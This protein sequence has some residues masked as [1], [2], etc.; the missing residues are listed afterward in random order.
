ME[1]CIVRAKYDFPKEADTDLSLKVGDIVRIIK[2]VNDEWCV[3]IQNK[4]QGQFPIAF[5]DVLLEN[6]AKEVFLAVADFSGQEDGDIS[7]KKDEIIS[8]K[9]NVDE[10]WFIG[11]SKNSCGLCPRSFVKELDFNLND[12]EH[13]GGKDDEKKSEEISEVKGNAD[14]V[15][16][17]PYGESVDAFSAQGSDELTFPK[18]VKIQ[19]VKEIDSFWTEGI[20]NGKQGKFP[21]LFIKVIEPLPEELQHKEAD[22]N[23]SDSLTPE[24]EPSAKALFMYIGASSDELSFDKGDIIT[25]KERVNNEW[26]RGQIGKTEGLFPAN[27][28]EIIVDL[29]FE[30]IQEPRKL[31]KVAQCTGKNLELSL[32]TN[33]EE[34]S[35]KPS[36]KQKP[37]LLKPKPAVKQKPTQQKPV[38]MNQNSQSKPLLLTSLKQ[39]QK[40]VSPSNTTSSKGAIVDKNETAQPLPKSAKEEPLPKQVDGLT[41]IKSSKNKPQKPP[42][43]PPVKQIPNGKIKQGNNT[44][45]GGPVEAKVKPNIERPPRPSKM[46]ADI[47][48]NVLVSDMPLLVS[49]TDKKSHRTDMKKPPISPKKPVSLNTKLLEKEL[50]SL[51]VEEPAT[52]KGISNS[53]FYLEP[54]PGEQ[55]TSHVPAENNCTQEQS[56]PYKRPAPKRP[57]RNPSKSATMKPGRSP[58]SKSPS[59]SPQD[60]SPTLSPVLS[61]SKE[62]PTLNGMQTSKSKTLPPKLPKPLA[63]LPPQNPPVAPKISRSSTMGVKGNGP[64]FQAY[65]SLQDETDGINDVFDKDEVIANFRQFY[66]CVQT[67]CSS[68]L[69][70]ILKVAT[71]IPCDF[72][73]FD[74]H[75]Q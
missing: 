54:D 70:L 23:E 13:V 36:L 72:I 26:Y 1:G 64:S 48:K 41:I 17:S 65:R 12:E 75:V 15:K 14:E 30:K 38:N 66:L 42:T 32:Q 55:N 57:D 49:N 62:R 24:T 39:Q 50:N 21:S 2:N 35:N 3:G 67:K 40:P 8:L 74:S 59:R 44:D 73:I 60:R 33:K 18:G 16:V 25:L 46:K 68:C 9:E 19:L 5:V 52:V 28:V 7:F 71:L 47:R 34:S 43:R 69:R 20:Y 4:Q 53:M 27:Y 29:P 56:K 31:E 61:H 63:P 6:A 51:H 22:V 45:K 10:N 11:V 37:L 58:Q